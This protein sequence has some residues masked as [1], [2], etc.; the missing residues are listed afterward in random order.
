MKNAFT[1]CILTLALLASA[2]Q[3]ENITQSGMA[4]DHF[5]IKSQGQT[6]PVRVAGNIDSK[7][8]LIVVHGGPGDSGF[9]YRDNYVV[10]NVE[11]EFAM[12]YWDQPFAGGAQGNGGNSSLT[13]FSDDLKKLIYLL[14]AKYGNDNQIFLMGHSWGG[15]VIP[16]FLIDGNN[17][18][19]VDGWIQVD[20]AHNTRFNPFVKEMMLTYGPVE[21]AA[22]REIE[23]WQEVL[24]FCNSSEYVDD[25]YDV[26]LKLNRYAHMAGSKMP[27][28]L[29][30]VYPGYPN[31]MNYVPQTAQIINSVN[32]V[33]RMGIF[34]T[35]FNENPVV[36]NLHLIHTPTLLLWGQYDFV[37]PPALKDDI[38]NNISSSDVSEHI[39]THSAHSPMDN[40]CE[41]FWAVVI[42]W[43]Q[44]H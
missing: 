1:A 28:V 33:L 23:F 35:A 15:F 8:M 27:Q 3:K 38:A 16:Y 34:E 22:G 6:I 19:L 40:E 24:D 44:S 42:N 26:M 10:E 36:G 12:V 17:Q 20:G 31:I 9:V 21:I 32:S 25:N 39:F 41:A 5:F 14:K 11:Q 18:S 29:E 30:P 43:V 4:N 7:K 37:C 13:V 2:C